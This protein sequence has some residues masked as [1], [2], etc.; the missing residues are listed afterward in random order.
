[1]ASHRPL[2]RAC[3]AATLGIT[4]AVYL[5]QAFWIAGTK[6]PWCDE[7][8]FANPA[9]NL[10]FRGNMGTNVLEPSGHFLNA[11]LRGIQERTYIVVPNH[12]VALAAWFRIF[13]FSLFTM[14]AWSILWG[15]I[16][17]PVTFY[18][19]YR[20]LPDPRI[21]LLTTV[22]LSLDFVFLWSSADGRMDATAA[23]LALC[24]IAAY[25]HW[26][27]RNLQAAVLFSQ[28]CGAAAAFTHPN[29]LLGLIVVGVLAWRFDRARL[30]LRWLFEA[31]TP[32]C[33]FGLAWLLYIAQSPSEFRAQFLANAAGRNSVRWLVIVQ[34][35]LAVWGELWRHVVTYLVSGLWSAVMKQWMFFIP[36]LYLG[37]LTWFFRTYRNAPSPGFRMFHICAGTY[38]LGMTF[39]NGFKAPNYLIYMLP[40]YNAVLA[41]WL[42]RQWD[43]GRDARLLGATVA[44]AFMAAQVSTTV[45]HIRADEYRDYMAATQKLEMYRA[46]GMTMVGTSALGFGVGFQG[47]RD[48]ARLGL[49]SGLDPDV[50][51]F[52]RSY[53]WFAHLF[54]VE[55]PG[56]FV[57]VART[58]TSKF[59]LTA[60]C[61][62]FWIF[63][64]E[65]QPVAGIDLKTLAVK[66]KRE[67]ADYLFE[68]IEQYAE[69]R[70]QATNRPSTGGEQS[71]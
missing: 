52:D 34:P 4:L 12:L 62:S 35:W 13:G 1:M 18:I 57:H 41:A 64:R 16:T 3:I 38:V 53:Q 68:W 31:A 23:A 60:K 7:G 15:A 55:E 37:A 10:A 56:V 19:L 54:A 29:A 67:Q 20:L 6:A 21:A 51:V 43:R 63:E 5:L 22:L 45:Q 47:F 42:I 69:R 49:Y 25:L 40:F 44:A 46:S 65:A 14:R 24:G 33:I 28:V 48:D 59:R 17:L 66:K 50:V 11:Y 32:Y 27:E 36:F 30:R 58:L 9:Y 26:R 2:S 61:G 71:E 39:L 8:W 70:S